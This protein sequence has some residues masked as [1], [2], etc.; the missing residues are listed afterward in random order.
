MVSVPAILLVIGSGLFWLVCY[1]VLGM[2]VETVGYRFSE[3]RLRVDLYLGTFTLL[4][5]AL[6]LIFLGI[7]L[8]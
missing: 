4:Y 6:S 1:T 3:D 5:L 2:V 8:R 7:W